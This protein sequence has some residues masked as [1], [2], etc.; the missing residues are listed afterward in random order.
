MIRIKARE[1]VSY[2]DGTFGIIQAERPMNPAQMQV[3]RDLFPNFIGQAEDLL[4]KEALFD[5]M[6]PGPLPD[7]TA[8]SVIEKKSKPS[9]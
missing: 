9:Y 2:G 7:L 5:A 4:D 1:V 8:K 6:V 3:L